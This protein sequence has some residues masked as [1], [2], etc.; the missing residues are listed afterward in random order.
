MLESNKKIITH[1]CKSLYKTL[2]SAGSHYRGVY[3]DI[4]LSS[5]VLNAA[6]S[7]DLPHLA[8]EYLGLA[9]ISEGSEAQVIYAIYE[10]ITEKLSEIGD[11]EKLLYDIEMPL[12]A[13]LA[14]MEIAGFRI[15]TD[16]L[17]KY[18]ENLDML[19][20]DLE[21]R[22]YFSAGR[23]FNINS[24]AQLGSVL[25]ETLGLPAG[26]KTKSGSYS[27]GADILEKLRP[28][29]PIIED[30]LEYRKVTKLKSTYVEGLI[31][32]AD[33]SG[34]VHSC[35]NQTGTTTGRLSSSEPNLQ[36]IP[37]RT[38]LGRELRKF[39]VPEG[40]DHRL[41]DADYSQIELRVLASIS[42]DEAMTSAFISGEDIHAST[43]STV[44]GVPKNSVTTEMRKR[45][46]AINF[47]IVYGM[48]EFSLAEDLGI[49]RAQA[50]KY[51]ESYLSG[52]PMVCAYL[53]GIVKDAYEHGYVTTLFGRR[54]Y[55]P[56]LAGQNK[57]LKHFGERVAKNSPIQ[58]TAADIIKIAMIN[59]SK[60][61]KESG[62]DARLILQVHDELI[63]EAHKD[64]AD[65]A[66]RILEECMENA[67]TLGVPLLAKASIGKTWFDNK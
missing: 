29:H 25:F 16:G 35:F 65:Q 6:G 51:I 36:N 1:D 31:K 39:F 5:Y 24:P 44:F 59:T 7:F 41:I 63:L 11:S 17:K 67:V 14:D 21:N 62:I 46:K 18:G 60:K 23:E 38:E 66:A 56:E 20:K 9:S 27:T 50:K 37:I 4:M 47:G 22:I 55:I 45:A 64:C 40:E 10:K 43:A 61:L 54:R 48:G 32:V 13:V 15:D 57:N 52:Y 8:L 34:R 42:G 49:S 3:H 26:K 33:D 58:G 2:D 30:I 19:A 28:H 12:A 53:D